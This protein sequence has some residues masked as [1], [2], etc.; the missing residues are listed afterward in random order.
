M[1]EMIAAGIIGRAQL[2]GLEALG[3]EFPDLS[4]ALYAVFR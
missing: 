1:D 2:D 4:T 3:A